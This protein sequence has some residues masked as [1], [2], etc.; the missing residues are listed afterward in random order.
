MNPY[1]NLPPDQRRMQ[2]LVDQLTEDEWMAL[3]SQFATLGMGS[4]NATGLTR[5]IPCEEKAP[6]VV[7]CF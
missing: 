1:Y 7:T 3:R 6:S 5:A 2:R 4:Q